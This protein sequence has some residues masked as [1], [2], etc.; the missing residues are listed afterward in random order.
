MQV[1]TPFRN[2]F[3]Q[4]RADALPRGDGKWRVFLFLAS[5]PRQIDIDALSAGDAI[6]GA[7]ERL[8]KERAS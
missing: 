3:S 5:G 1:M 6:R 7:W 8:R 2:G 4:G